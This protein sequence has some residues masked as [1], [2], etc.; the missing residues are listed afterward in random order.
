MKTLVFTPLALLWLCSSPGIAQ[1]RERLV[2]ESSEY[3]EDIAS[4]GPLVRTLLFGRRMFISRDILLQTVC[5]P[6]FSPPWAIHLFNPEIAWFDSAEG[7]RC[8]GSDTTQFIVELSRAATT[9]NI[10]SKNYRSLAK[11]TITKSKVIPKHYAKE[12]VEAFA[13][14][15][16]IAHW[17]TDRDLVQIDGS[18]YHFAVSQKQG[19]ESSYMWAQA[20]DPSKGTR[21]EQLVT[22]AESLASY[23]EASSDS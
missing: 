20:H 13:A 19:V 14:T 15:L 5:I 16:L 21:T 11:K 3:F 4:K 12:A 2:Y 1:E 7:M 6:S 10:E 18:E 22:L 9:I 23:A 17:P 8:Y